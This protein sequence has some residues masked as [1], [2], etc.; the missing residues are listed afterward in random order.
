L[1]NV[2]I[3]IFEKV[4]K[5]SFKFKYPF[6]SIQ[7][8][9]RKFKNQFSYS[10]SFPAQRPR[11]PLLFSFNLRRKP[12]AQSAFLGP[13]TQLGPPGHLFFLPWTKQAPPPVGNASPQPFAF[14]HS[15]RSGNEP[16]HCLSSS[17]SKT[18]ALTPPFPTHED[19]WSTHRPPDRLLSTGHLP[20][21]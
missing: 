3:S 11:I 20:S 16:P 8:S 18:D 4:Q 19:L 1:I 12:Q 15:L 17:P 10:F 2:P 9:H 7:T 6:E 13:S 5:L 14:S 21:P